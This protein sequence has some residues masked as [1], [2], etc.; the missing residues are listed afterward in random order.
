M[1]QSSE[2]TKYGP[3]GESDDLRV[4]SMALEYGTGLDP[5]G[6]LAWR[7]QFLTV[8]NQQVGMPR[9]RR[10]VAINQLSPEVSRA[11]CSPGI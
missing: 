11:G 9:G 2:R 4:W 1:R 5:K 3:D 7:H 8:P 6:G 10:W